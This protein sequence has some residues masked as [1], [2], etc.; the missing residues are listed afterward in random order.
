M[1][2]LIGKKFEIQKKY[3]FV[4]FGHFS[5]KFFSKPLDVRKHSNVNADVGSRTTLQRRL[6]AFA[7]LGMFFR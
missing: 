5:K 1:R 3:F 7:G 4:S 2:W 6:S